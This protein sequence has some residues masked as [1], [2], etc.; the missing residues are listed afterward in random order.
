VA[1]VT[2]TCVQCGGSFFFEAAFYEDRR[3]NYP[4]RCFTCRDAVRTKRKQRT[5][6][7]LTTGPS[8][9]F[10]R[11]DGTERQFYAGPLPR[12]A[13]VSFEGEDEPAP[14]YKSPKAFYVEVLP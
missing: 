7:V 4:R 11:E 2:K 10:I 5:G 14:G 3:L 8:F 9:S 1:T 6:R 12:G 13:R